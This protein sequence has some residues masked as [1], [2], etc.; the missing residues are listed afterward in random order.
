MPKLAASATK[1]LASISLMLELTEQNAAEILH[2]HGHL[3]DPHTAKVRE[4]SGGV[5]NA[6]FLIE[7]AGERFV[8]KQARGKLRVQADWQC[9]VERI[10]REVEV[11]R[12][13]N[14]ILQLG[15]HGKLRVPHI[16]W[17]DQD[18]FAYAMTA[19]EE[20]FVPWKNAILGGSWHRT[21]PYSAAMLLREVHAQSWHNNS[22]AE[23]FKD[24]T[25]FNQLRLEPYYL[26]S[27]DAYP[28][29]S[30]QLS[31]LVDQ[32]WNERHALVH[33]DF[34]PKN[35]LVF[36]GR[37][38]LIDFEVGHYGDPAFD[39][40][41]FLSHLVLKAI[42]LPH[43]KET[44]LETIKAFW[45]TY[46]LE[47]RRVITDVEYVQLESRTV[48]HLAGCLVARV[49][50]KS[51]VDYLTPPEQLRAVALAEKLFD[52]GPA[53]SWHD[54]YQLLQEV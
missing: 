45:L 53:A 10:W 22:F 47:I 24:R 36:G 1:S 35:M 54:A 40:G 23:R 46:S 34:S 49:H 11:L 48:Q 51:P 4:L 41:F 43:L 25:F 15:E 20:N 27:A 5:S 12:A 8:V 3:T 50:G 2:A 29:L 44:M 28:R 7:Q 52:L 19:A 16:H 38:M 42:H 13:Y 18:L 31:D 6:V 37:F 30:T 32:A 21:N 39:L 9:S 14:E 26:A 17:V 33:G